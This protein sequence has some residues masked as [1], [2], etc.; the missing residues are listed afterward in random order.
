MSQVGELTPYNDVVDPT[1]LKQ[2]NIGGESGVVKPIDYSTNTGKQF[3][4]KTWHVEF[5][6][7]S[8]KITDKSKI[9]LHTLYDALKNWNEKATVGIVGHTDNTGTVEG[10]NELSLERA[11]SVKM[12][13]IEL[14]NGIFPSERF[15]V[16]GKGQ[17]QPIDPSQNQNS[18]TVRKNNRRVE[19]TMYE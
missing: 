10:N 5:E 6:I 16:D 19:I 3:A 1:Y 8:S 15:K 17:S 11:R 14:S 12:F 18:P 7:G 4:K 2:V 9:E 13:L